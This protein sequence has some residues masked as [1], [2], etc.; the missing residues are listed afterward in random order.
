MPSPYRLYGFYKCI[1]WTTDV[2]SQSSWCLEEYIFKRGKS[3]IKQIFIQFQI[4]YKPHV[5][6]VNFKPAFNNPIRNWIIVLG[7]PTML[8]DIEQFR[9]DTVQKFRTG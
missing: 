7:I 6:F 5:N 1:L 3:N 8:C 2:A 9:K 4:L